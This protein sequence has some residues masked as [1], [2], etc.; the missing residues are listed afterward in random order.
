[1]PAVAI[2]IVSYNTRTLLDECLTSLREDADSGLA[3]VWVV[4]NTSTDGSADMVAADHPW[5]RL[6]RSDV[7]LGYGPA[8]NVVAARTDTPWIACANSDLTFTRGAVRALLD[9]G[10]TH[11]EAAAIAPRLILPDGSTQESV[12]AFPSLARS[13]L[14]A[15]HLTAVS[16]AVRRRVFLPGSWDPDVG[17]E[18]PWA[19]GAFLIL[20]RTAFDAVGRFDAEQ[21]MY[22]EDLD[23]G[24]RLRRAGWTT[25]YEPRAVVHHHESA[26]SKVAFGGQAG[27]VDKWVRAN[28]A[29]MVRRQGLARTWATAGVEA[30]EAGARV[31]AFTAL[32]RRR[33]ERFAPRLDDARRDL[34]GARSG[35]RSRRTLLKA[36]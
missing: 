36:I 1:M 31:A 13:A 33:P 2:A 14:L 9:A 6:V 20:R 19:T 4:D 7:N 8:V 22:A 10:E 5:V 27:V 21:W 34:H 29:W 3:E 26:A 17:Q 28:H 18:V 30:L 11:P 24:W 12:Q 35:L 25:R 15:S 16:P 32:A 23:L